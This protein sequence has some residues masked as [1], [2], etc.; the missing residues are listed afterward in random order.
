MAN[1]KLRDQSKLGSS[2]ESFSKEES[3]CLSLSVS[4]SLSLCLKKPVKSLALMNI[5][6]DTNL[7]FS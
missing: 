3:V 7:C 6:S 2:L 4:S 5:L 1:F